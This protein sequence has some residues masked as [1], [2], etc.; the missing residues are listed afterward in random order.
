MP[1]DYTTSLV[2]E[3]DR[4]AD[5]VRDGIAK[6]GL[7]AFKNILDSSGF[8]KSEHLKNYELYVHVSDEEMTFEILLDIEAVQI[9]NA[10]DQKSMNST[11]RKKVKTYALDKSNNVQKRGFKDVRKPA[12]DARKTGHDGRKTSINRS[13]EHEFMRFVP[14]GMELDRDGKLAVSFQKS[15]K[16]RSGGFQY[17]KGKFDGIINEFLKKLETI[18]VEQFGPEIEKIIT[19]YVD[20]A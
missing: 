1:L 3:L 9:D 2:A 16:K 7:I 15:M 6:D 8:N 12:K 17:P 11:I 18:I 5:R 19:G 14:N 10:D 20:N 13:V 4:A